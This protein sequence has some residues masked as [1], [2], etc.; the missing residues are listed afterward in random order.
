MKD[1]PVQVCERC[2]QENAVI[3]LNDQKIVVCDFNDQHELISWIDIMMNKLISEIIINN[4][5]KKI[6]DTQ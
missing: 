1:F 5:F 4:P 3:E 6:F 2:E